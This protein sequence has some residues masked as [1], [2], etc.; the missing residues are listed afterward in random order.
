MDCAE[1]EWVDSGM[2]LLFHQLLFSKNF[3]FEINLEK[4]E[5]QHRTKMHLMRNR[6]F[7]LEGSRICHSTTGLLWCIFRQEHAC[8]FDFSHQS[9]LL[10][11]PAGQGFGGFE[12]R[13]TK[14]FKRSIQFH[15]FDITICTLLYHLMSFDPIV[16]LKRVSLEIL[17]FH[18]QK[19]IV[20]HASGC[21]S[22]VA[23]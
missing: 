17:S 8:G 23:L 3:V 15:S 19:C 14:P 16:S 22:P 20:C 18:F 5:L 1:S 21:I 13:G 2:P 9:G 6:R 11:V 4:S 7:C 12:L 10:A